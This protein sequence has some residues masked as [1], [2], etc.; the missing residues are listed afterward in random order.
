MKH[1]PMEIT[2][3]AE[4]LIPCPFCARDGDMLRVCEVFGE[5]WIVCKYCGANSGAMG[6]KAAALRAWN[7]RDYSPGKSKEPATHI[8]KEEG[9]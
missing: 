3:S 5:V 9:E 1:G 2:H 4:K 7:G 6:D 8:I